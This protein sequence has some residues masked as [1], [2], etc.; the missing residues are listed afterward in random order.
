[1]LFSPQNSIIGE[2]QINEM[3]GTCVVG[4]TVSGNWSNTQYAGT[5]VDY[6]GLSFIAIYS[7][8]TISS[9][10]PTSVSPSVWGS[11][12]GTQTATFTYT[13]NRFSVTV[14]KDASVEAAIPVSLSISGDWSNTQYVEQAVDYTGLVF[15]VTYSDGNSSV[16]TPTSLNPSTWSSTVGVQSCTFSYT[17]DGVTV[18]V[19]KSADVLADGITDSWSTIAERADAG[20]AAQYYAVG[21]FKYVN[22]SSGTVDQMSVNA[23]TYRAVI[24]GINHNPTYENEHAI[25]FCIGQNTS[26]TDI[27]FYNSTGVRMNTSDI[28][29]GGWTGSQM[30]LTYLPQ[31]YSLLS[32]NTGLQ[33]AM[34][35]PKKYTNNVSG[36]STEDIEANVTLSE[37][38]NYKIFLMAEF[39][40]FGTRKLAN[41][42]EQNKQAQ[43]AYYSSS[44][45]NKSKI[46]Y[47]TDTGDAGIWWERSAMCHP[48]DYGAPYFLGVVYKNGNAMADAANSHNGF[49]PCFRV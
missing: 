19:S 5:A 48:D 9:V 25:D 18:S 24:I 40:I 23:G 3:L 2:S 45:L 41:S 32:R 26:G 46:R 35:A 13:E 36:G 27:C 12:V 7:N 22:V 1:M 28:T 39:E 10:T 14:S 8:G 11:T 34:I 6:T 16:V 4:L 38:S 33:D 17:E 49:C 42:Y 43:Y 44:G 31:F 20:T 37:N 15:T 47:R 30:Y 21:D 29:T